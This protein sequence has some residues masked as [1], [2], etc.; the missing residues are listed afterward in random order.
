MAHVNVTNLHMHPRTKNKKNFKSFF[1]F[2]FLSFDQNISLFNCY[3]Q[4]AE[5][6]REDRVVKAMPEG[7]D[8]SQNCQEAQL[9]QEGW[10]PGDGNT[11]MSL[12]LTM[13]TFL[14]PGIY[15]LNTKDIRPQRS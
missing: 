6:R 10:G 15:G 4:D 5:P 11:P 14:D 9:G 13:T 2:S 8:P 12:D 7:L 1:T 3:I